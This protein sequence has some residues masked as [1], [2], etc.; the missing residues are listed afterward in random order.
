MNPESEFI[1]TLHAITL[2]ARQ[3]GHALLPWD[4]SPRAL[5]WQCSAATCRHCGHQV[6]VDGPHVTGLGSPCP[7]PWADARGAVRAT[8]ATALVAVVILAVMY[9]FTN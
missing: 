8:I 7:G 2:S 6:A 5:H 4:L 3:D 9:Y 1:H